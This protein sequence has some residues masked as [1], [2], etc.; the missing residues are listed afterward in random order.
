MSKQLTQQAVIT[1]GTLFWLR[2]DQSATKSQTTFE[3][4]LNLGHG[5]SISLPMYYAFYYQ[6]LFE[7]FGRQ[8]LSSEIFSSTKMNAWIHAMCLTPGDSHETSSEVQAFFNLATNG[9]ELVWTMTTLVAGL[10]ACL[11]PEEAIQ[12]L[13]TAFSLRY[14]PRC[15]VPR[16]G[17]WLTTDIPSQVALFFD[18]GSATALQKPLYGLDCTLG[19]RLKEDYDIMSHLANKCGLQEEMF[20]T[21]NV[22][23]KSSTAQQRADLTLALVALTSQPSCWH[24]YQME[25]GT[26]TH[27]SPRILF[28]KT[29]LCVD[30]SADLVVDL[31]YAIQSAGIPITIY[32]QDTYLFPPSHNPEIHNPE[33]LED[34]LDLDSYYGSK[35]Y[36]HHLKTQTWWPSRDLYLDWKKRRSFDRE[37]SRES[38][39]RE[40]PHQNFYRELSL[41][42]F[43]SELPIGPFVRESPQNMPSRVHKDHY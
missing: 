2:G 29:S 32:E 33:I 41:G 34:V 13:S 26:F 42:S 3:L 20:R 6:P 28:Y 30:P 4:D 35:E 24:T 23:R 15:V 17:T 7:N 43:V 12:V 31:L 8:T 9:N 5:V 16:Q 1:F 38:F 10:N 37:L 40:T 39:L 22:D 21:L 25:R 18:K 14:D 19:R 11:A 27:P 36:N